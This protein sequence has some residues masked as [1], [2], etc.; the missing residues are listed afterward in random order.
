MD[1]I[2]F[3]NTRERKAYQSGLAI[4]KA[5]LA[6]HHKPT[7]EEIHQRS[8]M[9]G[10]VQVAVLKKMSALY[11]NGIPATQTTAA[12]PITSTASTRKAFWTPTSKPR[13]TYHCYTTRGIF[14]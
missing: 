3:N 13:P 4:V 2:K 5:K 12:K 1:T 6:L 7:A 9:E 8:M 14:A 11:K 10:A